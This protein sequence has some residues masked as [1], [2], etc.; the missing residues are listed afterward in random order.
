MERKEFEAKIIMEEWN[1][2]IPEIKF[3]IKKKCLREKG[4]RFLQKFSVIF[5]AENKWA[6]K[7]IRIHIIANII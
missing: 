4:E 6:H 7:F 2:Y 1:E 3:K 5:G